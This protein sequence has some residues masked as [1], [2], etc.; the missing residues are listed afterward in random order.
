MARVI[1][2]PQPEIEVPQTLFVDRSS[3][4]LK[5]DWPKLY[6]GGFLVPLQANG[7]TYLNVR[8]Y[9]KVSILMSATKAHSI[10]LYMGKWVPNTLCATFEWT[11]DDKIHTFDILG[12][13]IALFMSSP[14]VKSTPAED[15]ELWLYLTT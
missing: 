2:L 13:E 6:P 1:P 5:I 10:L 7:A 14:F 3:P 12:P 9:R 8:A 15:V 11:P 4:V